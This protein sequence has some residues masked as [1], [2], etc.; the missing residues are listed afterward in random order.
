MVARI[1]KNCRFCTLSDLYKITDGEHSEHECRRRSP[2]V[3]SSSGY[4]VWPVVNLTESCGEFK[5][6]GTAHV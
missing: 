1:C 6:K 5:A 4:R 3:Q 2:V